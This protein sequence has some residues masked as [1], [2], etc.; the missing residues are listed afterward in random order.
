MYMLSD[1]K[2][3]AIRLVIFAI[4]V[5]FSRPAFAQYQENLN[6]DS[7]RKEIPNKKSDTALS[8]LY[9][10]I[11]MNFS[12]QGERDSAKL[13]AKKSLCLV[14]KKNPNRY[15]SWS[16]LALGRSMGMVGS[17]DSTRY[18]YQKVV[19]ILNKVNDPYL[20]ECCYIRFG[21]YY[22]NQGLARADSAII[23]FTKAIGVANKIGDKKMLSNAYSDIADPYGTKND[24]ITQVNY[25]KKSI[26]LAEKSSDPSLI[27]NKLSLLSNY[28]STKVKPDYSKAIELLNRCTELENKHNLKELKLQTLSDFAAIYYACSNMPKQLQYLLECS[29]LAGELRDSASM[30]DIFY[31]IALLYQ[32]D[33]NELALRNYER[34]LAIFIRKQKKFNIA[35][36]YFQMGDTYGG[37]H[38]STSQEEYINKAYNCFDSI[39][40]DWGKALCLLDLG[41]IARREKDIEK[42]VNCFYRS[43]RINDSIGSETNAGV[44]LGNL[45]DNMLFIFDSEIVPKSHF[46]DSVRAE[47][48]FILPRLLNFTSIMIVNDIK[49]NMI[50]NLKVDYYHR[51][52]ILAD[53]GKYDSAYYYYNLFHVMSDSINSGEK[54]T[55]VERITLN[56]DISEKEKEIQISKL[57]LEQ[58]KKEQIYYLIGLTGASI[59]IVV[60]IILYRRQKQTNKLLD[61]EKKNSD[62]LLNEVGIKNKEITDNINYAQRIQSAILPDIKL[63]YKTLGQSFILYL[64]KDIVSGDF[65]GFAERDNK[66]IIIA[67]DCTGHG[68]S[69]A[70]MSMIGSS[71]LNQVINEKGITEPAGI[72]NHLNAAVIEALNQSNNESNDG[73][74]VSI[75]AF[76]L[77]HLKIEYA[78]ANRPLW[79][80]RNGEMLT[81]SPDKY[82]IGGL[83]IARDRTFTNHIID[84]EKGDTIYIFSD[85]YADQFGGEKG[86][87]LMTSKFKEKLLSIQNEP[88]REQERILQEYFLEWKG[89]NEQVD[90]VL[91]IGV[92]V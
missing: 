28:F 8:M 87:K 57:S 76:D 54:K 78:G 12:A 24:T 35:L 19:D 82:P 49:D 5:L 37:L 89:S 9:T 29:E 13:Y 25:L 26:D 11:S 23:F 46:V 67:A 58:K 45:C 74:D 88:M 43:Y 47:R 63:I 79:I 86:K 56:R 81:F 50:S 18:F 6:I 83:Q 41:A 90:D 65:Y 66:V 10:T 7:L 39:H 30:A 2:N 53:L 3:Q 17:W 55:M 34:A 36:T 40:N 69:G 62:S 27:V 73:M 42:A 84:L 32:G 70:F 51:A 14:E 77:E 38:S 60:T 20:S 1:I 21:R 64:S 59:A 22:N 61:K 33:N 48:K 68:V 52:R 16:Y 72:L 91:V 44:A 92:R 15:V 80:A 85:G 4:F 75:C 71:L 31:R